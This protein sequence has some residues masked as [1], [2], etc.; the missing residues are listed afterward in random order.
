MRPKASRFPIN[1]VAINNHKVLRN[2]ICLNFKNKRFQSLFLATTS[3]PF[4]HKRLQKYCNYHLF[5][6]PCAGATLASLKI[7]LASVAFQVHTKKVMKQA[8]S[9][10][11]VEALD[12]SEYIFFKFLLQ[13]MLH[14]YSTSFMS[15]HSAC[16]CFFLCFCVCFIDV[17]Q[18]LPSKV[19]FKDSMTVEYR[20]FRMNDQHKLV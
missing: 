18:A 17:N 7:F 1:Y 11:K 19:K 5:L 6:S 8:R 12:E 4:F 15:R 9:K 14:I 3:K 10:S 2:E 13:R 16:V 20:N